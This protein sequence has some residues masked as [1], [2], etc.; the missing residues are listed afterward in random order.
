MA[1][2]MPLNATMEDTC[3]FTDDEITSE[4]LTEGIYSVGVCCFIRDAQHFVVSSDHIAEKLVRSSATLV[5]VAVAL[6]MQFY[7]CYSTKTLITPDLVNAARDIYSKYEEVMYTDYEH[8][9]KY[10]TKTVNGRFRG[11]P[12]EGHFFPKNFA[13]LDAD[14]KDLACRIPLSQPKFFFIVLMI[15][16]LTCIADIRKATNLILRVNWAVPTISTMAKS[17]KPRPDDGDA[18]QQIVGLTCSFKIFLTCFLLIPRLLM[19]CFLLWLGSRFLIASEAFG[20]LLLNAVALEFILLLRETLYFAIVPHR[21]Q[22][23]TTLTFLPHLN[24]M[25]AEGTCAHVGMFTLLLVSA[26]W[27]L[28]YMVWLQA[29]LPDYRWDVRAVCADFLAKELMA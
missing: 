4:P 17:L 12:G 15:W 10:L 22:E 14:E 5:V 23:E 18:A 28:F 25:S 9:K 7:L 1:E 3:E 13:L 21:V 11:T 2:L 20:D 27:A 26:A 19:A 29:V 16:S 8:D 24:R 6:F